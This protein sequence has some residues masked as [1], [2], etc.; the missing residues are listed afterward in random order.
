MC[1]HPEKNAVFLKSMVELK[2]TNVIW[3]RPGFNVTYNS[4]AVFFF[5]SEDMFVLTIHVLELE[6]S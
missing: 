3:F 5:F 2:S 1:K 6:A 4:S